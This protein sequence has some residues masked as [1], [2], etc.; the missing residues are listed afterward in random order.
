MGGHHGGGR[1]LRS[2]GTLFHFCANPGCCNLLPPSEARTRPRAKA[3]T[4]PPGHCHYKS[5]AVQYQEF[6]SAGTIRTID[7]N[8]DG[9]EQGHDGF[10]TVIRTRQSC[11]T[12]KF[13][14]LSW[15]QLIGIVSR[16]KIRGRSTAESSRSLLEALREMEDEEVVR[17]VNDWSS[18]EWKVNAKHV[19]KFQTTQG[20]YFL[21]LEKMNEGRRT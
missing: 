10:K 18:Q 13:R 8:G 3:A 16:M 2:S 19:K 14:H 17:T 1:K 15:A 6:Q 21:P 12:P 20:S 4:C 7:H 11:W 5:F 9:F